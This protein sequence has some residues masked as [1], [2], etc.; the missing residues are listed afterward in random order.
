LKFFHFA[1]LI[2]TGLI[3]LS[4]FIYV[5]PPIEIADEPLPKE[6][7]D[8][9]QKIKELEQLTATGWANGNRAQLASAFTENA[10]YITFNGNG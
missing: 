3:I 8:D 5:T 1:L 9:I 2:I 4:N 7:Q 6:R 10:D